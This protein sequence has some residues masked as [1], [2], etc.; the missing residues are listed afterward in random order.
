MSKFHIVGQVFH[1]AML[2]RIL[3]TLIG[4]V[5][6]HLEEQTKSKETETRNEVLKGQK[7]QLD[8]L[9]A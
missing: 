2:H 4:D 1:I 7:N 8:G 6:I 5:L 3:M 9:F